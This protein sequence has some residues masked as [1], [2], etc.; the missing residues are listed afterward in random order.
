MGSTTTIT[1]ITT[2]RHRLRFGAAPHGNHQVSN[3]VP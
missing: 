1:I 3:W 2:I